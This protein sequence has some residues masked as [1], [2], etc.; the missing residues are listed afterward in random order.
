MI[1]VCLTLVSLQADSWAQIWTELETLRGGKISAA[2]A[3][4]LRDHLGEALHKGAEGP[5]AD[6]LGA[7]LEALAGRDATSAAKRMA[8]LE[9]SPFSV[10]ER[11]FLA[12]LLPAGAE[13]ARVVLTA[14]ETPAPLAD[15]QALLAW[16]TAVDEVRALRI[17]E[18]ALPIQ[19]DLHER[20]DADWSAGDLALT[21]MA[22]GQGDAAV[23]VLERAIERVRAG[24]GNLAALLERRG[25]QALG[26]GDETAARDY[27][28]LALAMRSDDA[29]LLLSRLDLLAG[30]MEAARRGFQA[31]VLGRPPPDWAW[32]GW[33]MALL[34][35]AF[36]EPA[37]VNR[38][39]PPE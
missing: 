34:P 36:A 11:W 19:L 4:V 2:E 16:N 5:R 18:T 17:E 27:L 21:Y 24:G 26:F 6:L 32:R 29:G 7:A 15:W 33:G 38:F 8:T 12:D 30:R 3:G 23:G 37:T 13:R 10:R 28:G 14:L 35:P 20:Y 31:L 1:A 9:P 25:I 22:L 39:P